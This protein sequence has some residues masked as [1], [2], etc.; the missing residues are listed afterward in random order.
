MQ[1]VTWNINTFVP[2]L[3]WWSGDETSDNYLGAHEL[4][5][6]IELEKHTSIHFGGL[7]WRITAAQGALLLSNSREASFLGEGLGENLVHCILQE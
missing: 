5:V 2:P 4:D 7:L 1:K 6:V 3:A